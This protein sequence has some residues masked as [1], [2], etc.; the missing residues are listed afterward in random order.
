MRSVSSTATGA[1]TGTGTSHGDCATGTTLAAGFTRR[2]LAA[3]CREPRVF[4]FALAATVGC[5]AAPPTLGEA[6][7]KKRDSAAWT[8]SALPTRPRRV[9]ALALASAPN[10]TC[11]TRCA[12]GGATAMTHTCGGA[13]F[14]GRSGL[15]VLSAS[16]SRAH[17]STSAADT[18]PATRRHATLEPN[19]D[20][21]SLCTRPQVA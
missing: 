9:A 3:N 2:S 19:G 6:T 12:S 14:G 16:P 13:A 17:C 7:T 11:A 18:E 20:A 10:S 15:P 4:G 21:N 8:A 1:G 5:R